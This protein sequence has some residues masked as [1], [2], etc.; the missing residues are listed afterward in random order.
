MR[1][2]IKGGTI[3]L[4][5]KIFRKFH[6]PKD[7][8]CEIKIDDKNDISISEIKIIPE[9]QIRIL[10]AKLPTASIEQMIN[11]EEINID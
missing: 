3:I 11:N 5:P 7:G 9:N 2:Q 6:L 10:K 1:A 4:P 8:E